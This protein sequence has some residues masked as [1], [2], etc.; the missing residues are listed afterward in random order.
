MVVK[1]EVD[2]Y[3]GKGVDGK[4]LI[5]VEV[6]KKMLKECDDYVKINDSSVYVEKYEKEVY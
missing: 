5:C 4:L 3:W 6:F 1:K 2:V